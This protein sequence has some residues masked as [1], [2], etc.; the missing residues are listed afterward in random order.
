MR[1][2]ASAEPLA[3]PGTS[4]SPKSTCRQPSAACS[5]PAHAASVE[6][7]VSDCLSIFLRGR[8]EWTE[9]GTLAGGVLATTGHGCFDL[10]RPAGRGPSSCPQRGFGLFGAGLALLSAH[11]S[12]WMRACGRALSTT[13][14]P[15]ELPKISLHENKQ[16]R[17]HQHC[18][19]TVGRSPRRR[20][21]VAWGETTYG[22][23]SRHFPRRHINSFL[24]R[25]GKF[26]RPAT[27]AQGFNQLLPVP[28]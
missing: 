7:F 4:H 23:Q 18:R 15:A 20:D 1:R 21:L 5:S 10:C 12:S 19:Q 16:E 24:R 11:G 8:K 22:T 25:R 26:S 14:R 28:P 17:Q 13:R 6:R 2:R 27:G 3:V 9:T